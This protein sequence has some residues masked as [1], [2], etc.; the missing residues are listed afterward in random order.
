MKNWFD[1]IIFNTR[2]QPETSAIVMEDRVV[3]YGMLGAAIESCAQRV[4][5][6]NLANN[7]LAA[8]CI[9]NPIR[10]LTICLALFRIGIRSISLEPAHVGATAGLKCA[11]VLGDAQGRQLYA[12]N[13]RFIDVTDDWFTTAP[14]VTTS[15]PEPFSDPRQVCRQS[16]TSGSTGEPKVVNNTVG[17]IARDMVSGITSF[18]CE[19]V[20][21]LP[22]LSSIF[23]FKVACGI[24]ASKKTL[25]FAASPFQAIRMIELFSIDF[26]VTSTDQLVSLV[27]AARKSG[28]HVRSLRTVAAGGGIPTRAL[29]EA[30]TIYLCKD[31]RSRYGTSEVGLL[32]L[33][34]ASEMLSKPGFVGYVQPGFEIGV[35]D[36]G[37]NPCGP[38]E[39]GIVKGRV[40]RSG[41]KEDWTDHGDVGWITADGQVFVVG[42]TSDIAPADFAKASA[43][44]ISPVYEVEHLLRLEWDASDAAAVLVS[45][46]SGRSPPQIWIGIVDCK[47][48]SAE[49]LEAILRHRGIDG[50]VRLFPLSSIPRGANGKVQRGQLKSL[51]LAQAL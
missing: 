11:V 40:K 8:I 21:S 48:A 24:L 4:A 42:R 18:N 3:T 35:F 25:C 28:A 13:N 23:G 44:Q 38:G 39:T 43:R 17:Y 36:P 31:V 16:L 34:R 26:A 9:N 47:D 14:P 22:G 20:L 50:A 45:D 33:A 10:H 12:T 30:A 49:K 27:R 2:A 19:L 46:N 29:L 6:L 15:L 1:H 51:L 7:S 5:I 37:G 41:E 32:G